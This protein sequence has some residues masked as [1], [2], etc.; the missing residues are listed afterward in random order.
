MT[1]F[2]SH[3]SKFLSALG[4]F[5]QYFVRSR[6]HFHVSVYSRSHIFSFVRSRTIKMGFLFIKK[7]M[8]G[9]LQAGILTAASL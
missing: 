7:E 9:P 8:L 1:L 5:F 2:R 6:F 4:L 3:L